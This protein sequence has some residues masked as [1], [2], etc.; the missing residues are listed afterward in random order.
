LLSVISPLDVAR[1]DSIKGKE[2]Y[3]TSLNRR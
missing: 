1:L 2:I 3:Q